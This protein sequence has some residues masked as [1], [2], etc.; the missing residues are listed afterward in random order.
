VEFLKALRDSWVRVVVVVWCCGFLWFDAVHGK[1]LAFWLLLV[2][3]VLNA[4]LL[5]MQ[6]EARWRR[7]TVDRAV[8]EMLAG[9]E[10]ERKQMASGW[11]VF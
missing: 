1:W 4:V 9:I 8:D 2:V 6:L 3:L 11:G 10:A 5:G 7:R